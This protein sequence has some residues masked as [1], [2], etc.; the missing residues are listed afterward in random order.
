[1]RLKRKRCVLSG[2]T[3]RSLDEFY[4]ALS[5]QLAFPPHF[6][7]NLDALWDLLTTDVTGPIDLI[8]DDA[9]ASKRAMKRDYDR[10][11]ALLQRVAAAR[12]DLRL[13]LR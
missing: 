3:V 7:R 13:I 1:M 4:D 9:G 6:G 11:L 8:W 10:V 5:R 2:K 12:P